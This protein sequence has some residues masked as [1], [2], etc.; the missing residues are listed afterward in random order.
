MTERIFVDTNVLVY[1]RDSSEKLKQR[2][3]G[4]WMKQLWA[5]QSG[6]LSV[7]VLQEFYVTVT[8]KLKPGMTRAAAR[9]DVRNLSKWRAVGS[10]PELLEVAWRVQDDFR[11]SWW[12][13]LIIAAALRTDCRYV[14]TEDLDDG[15]ELDGVR[16]IDPFRHEPASIIA[17]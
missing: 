16:I 11:V 1:T 17:G 4:E 8:Q 9:E 3:A 7:Q 6:R 5:T 10:S 13:S 15:T 12:D 14:L 2:R